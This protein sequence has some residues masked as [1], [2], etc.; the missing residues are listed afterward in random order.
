MPLPP[1]FVGGLPGGMELAVIFLIL[2]LILVPVALVVLAL[3]YLR[4]G[5]GDSELERRVE[6]LEGQVEVLREELRDHEGD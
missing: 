6:N 1:A 5:S 4:D 2:L 3:Q